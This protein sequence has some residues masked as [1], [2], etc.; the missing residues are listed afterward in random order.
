MKGETSLE[1]NSKEMA[2]ILYA[3]SIKEKEREKEKNKLLNEL[4]DYLTPAQ[5]MYSTLESLE[6]LKAE[7]KFK[8]PP[9]ENKT[10]P[11][12]Y[13]FENDI[14]LH[15]EFKQLN[16]NA[17][18]PS[19]E[20]MPDGY[21]KLN[22]YYNKNDG[23]DSYVY[24]KDDKVVIVYRGTDD[25]AD[26]LDDLRMAF[27]NYSSQFKDAQAVYEKVKQNHPNSK[28]YVTGHSLGGSLSQ[29]V[30]TLNNIPAVTFNPFGAKKN[31]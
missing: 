26:V 30:G 16:L 6:K 9:Q 12:F 19:E 31:Y 13:S 7:L 21:E 20:P 2:K 27:R 25:R 24:K 11:P 23:F 18:H 17:Y 28:I 1:L 22:Y 8:L 29:L 10:T 4:W 15:E 14:K 3:D 5:R